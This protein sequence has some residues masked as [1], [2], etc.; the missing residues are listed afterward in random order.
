MTESNTSDDRDTTPTDM[1][2]DSVR[3][4]SVHDVPLRNE[5][6]YTDPESPNKADDTDARGLFRPSTINEI[7]YYAREG[8]YGPTI[9]SKPVDDAFKHGF[10]IV[11]D[12]TAGPDSDGKI[13]QTLDAVIPQYK[14]AKKK[15]RRD[16]L[17]ILMHIISDST[18]SVSDPPSPDGG[19]FEGFQLWTVDNLSE[20]LTDGDVADATQYDDD[21]VYVTDGREHGGVAIVD[22]IESPDHGDVIGYGI[23]ERTD[24]ENLHETTFVHADRCHH[25]VHSPEVDGKLGNNATGEHVGE[26]VL[27]PVLQPLKAAQ[28]GFWSIKEI[29]RR[30]SAPLH[31]IESPE[32]WSI[33]DYEKAEERAEN[34]SMASDAVLPPGAEL[35]V[36]EGVSEFDPEPYYTTL[37]KPICA[38]TM[39]TRSILEGTNTG[40]VSGSETDIKGYFSNIR[41]FQQQEIEDDLRAIATKI[42]QYDQTAIPRVADVQSVTFDWGPLFKVNSL[43]QAEGAVSMIT[44]ATNAIKNYVMTPDEARTLVSEEWASF[45]IDVSLDALTEDELDTL[46]RINMN[47]AG[48]GIKDNEPVNRQNPQTS[49]SQGGRPSGSTAQSDPTTDSLDGLS[50]EQLQRELQRR[51]DT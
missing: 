2:T 50:T 27:T 5:N 15:A 21:Q 23:N 22:D 49:G 29:L 20:D 37:V 42:S 24:S 8:P 36:A 35:S 6:R 32:S 28:L 43:E 44:A 39:F 41:V 14:L 25:F 12:N 3:P 4:E 40:T 1:F 31:A 34:I 26:S 45:D 38:G 19:T 51:D 17:A 46:D 48:Q 10:D 13:K 7:R 47:E 9:V 11:G 16:G 18:Q 30:Y 33:E